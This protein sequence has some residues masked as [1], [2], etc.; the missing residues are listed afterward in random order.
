MD[1]GNQPLDHLVDLKL[2]RVD[3]WDTPPRIAPFPSGPPLP[4]HCIDWDAAYHV[5]APLWV[6]RVHALP[7]CPGQHVL[8]RPVGSPRPEP[9]E[10]DDV[11][12]VQN[13][14]VHPVVLRG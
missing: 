1:P 3:H 8:C 7:R 2:G 4:L 5:L 12:T 11:V 13:Y 14:H 9:I 6:D 10:A